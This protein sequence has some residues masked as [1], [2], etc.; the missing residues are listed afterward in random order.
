M[1]FSAFPPRPNQ[2][3][4]I[5]AVDMWIQRAD[6]AILHESVPWAALLSGTSAEA[7]VRA[8]NLPLV[9]GYKGRGLDVVFTIDPTNG[10]DR[11]SEDP[12]LVAMG[13]SLAEPA[14][15]QAYRAYALAVASVLQPSHLGLAAETN[16]IRAVAPR[17]LYDAVV[18]SAN[19]AA[20]DLRAAG[21]TAPLYVS[22]QVE[23]AWGRPSGAFVGIDTD[24]QDFPF[25]T[26]LGLSSYPYLGGFAEPEQVPSDYYSSV[27]SARL[28]LL[29]VEGGWTSTGV[30][31]PD[32]QARWIK[33]QFELAAQAQALH[34]FQLLFTDLD[35]AAFGQAPGSPL[36]PFATI[37]LVSTELS[38]K[39]A[40]AEWDRAFARPRR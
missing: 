8:L 18:A 31:S 40:L 9:Q 13:R 38:P 36:S 5:R 25:A 15:Q 20:G 22:A 39:P 28:P 7:A 1:G 12:A 21:I 37:G 10:L 35:E 6:A 26:A 30:S 17:G 29:V 34:V 19:A 32:R 2:A 3:D 4:Y 23:V 14:V 24:R 33:R 27:N 16:L 11:R